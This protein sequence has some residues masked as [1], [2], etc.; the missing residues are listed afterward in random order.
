MIRKY[1]MLTC[2]CRVYLL[3]GYM[4]PEYRNMGTVSTKADIFS[5]GILILEIVTGQD[6]TT[7]V[8]FVEHVRVSRC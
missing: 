3:R 1:H 6:N 4:A 7:K 5:L 8:D 2:S